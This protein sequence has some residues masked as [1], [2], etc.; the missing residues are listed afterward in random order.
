MSSIGVSGTYRTISEASVGVSGTWRN[1]DGMWVGVSGT[2]R[3]FYTAIPASTLP[4]DFVV[5]TERWL[6]NYIGYRYE[7]NGDTVPVNPGIGGKYANLLYF[8]NNTSSG[9]NLVLTYEGVDESDTPASDQFTTMTID[10]V[11]SFTAASASFGTAGFAGSWTWSG[12]GT[13]LSEGGSYT[14]SFE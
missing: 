7:L 13:L 14:V 10:G 11:G 4:T 2:W 1:V 5:T 6:T 9:G 3:P 12:V 8:Y